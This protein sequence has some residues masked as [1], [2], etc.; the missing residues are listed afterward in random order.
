MCVYTVCCRMFSVS[1][2]EFNN[3]GRIGITASKITSLVVCRC[4]LVSCTLYLYMYVHVYVYSII[5]VCMH[6]SVCVSMSM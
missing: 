2:L 4:V 6:E 5:C 1:L 3:I